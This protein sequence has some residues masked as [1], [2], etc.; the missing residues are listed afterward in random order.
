MQVRARPLSARALPGRHGV[1]SL[2]M[3]NVSVRKR[4]P[5]KTGGT[6]HNALVR[7]ILIG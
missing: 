7:A 1:F 4:K 6:A 2:W 5:T 3:C